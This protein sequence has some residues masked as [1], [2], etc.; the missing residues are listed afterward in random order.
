MD[1]GTRE[2]VLQLGR[3]LMDKG[4]MLAVAESCTG[5]LVS[6]SLTD[7]PGSSAWFAGGVVAYSNEAKRNILGV[8][9][10]V[11]ETKGAVSGEA[12]QAMAK[13]VAG[14]FRA[15]VAVATSGI[16]GPDGGT[17]QKPVGT[18]WMAWE[19]P[20]GLEITRHHFTGER[21]EI[22]AQAVRTA[23]ATLLRLVAE[24]QTAKP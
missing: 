2:L 21:L 19:G 20:F 16:A 18:V 1:A 8:P 6:S 15:D 5:G 23:V 22:K 10:S 13:G 14:V 3:I 11:L 12:V 7:I 24:A 17:P 9:Q 4:W